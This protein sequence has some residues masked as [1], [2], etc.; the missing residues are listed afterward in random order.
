MELFTI[1]VFSYNNLDSLETTIRSIY[2]QTYP[3]IEVI[4]SDDCSAVSDISVRT[5]INNII[6]PYKNKFRRTYINVN[7][8]NVG[9]VK[10]INMVL[11]QI[12]GKYICLLGSGDQ[13]YKEDVL[14]KVVNF[15]KNTDY[16]LCYSK[17]LMPLTLNK[18][19][20]YPQHRV[21][22]A[23][24]RGNKD[25]LKLC[26]REVNHITTIGAFFTRKIFEKYEKFDENYVLLEDAPF[27]LTLLLDGVKIGF[28]DEIT[29]IHEKGGVSNSKM[30]NKLLEKDSVKTLLEIKYPQR[31]KFDKFTQRILKFKY[32]V[33]TGKK[34]LDRVYACV[35]YPDAALYLMIFLLKDWIKRKRFL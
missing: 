4:V 7:Q 17:Q 24:S 32:K 23:I 30:K 1:C 31:D 9:T 8:K 28:L 19:I 29:C 34:L 11:P 13:L 10:N 12:K 2:K 26:C 6:G 14:E 25:L 18:Q 15:F 3:D 33:R 27:F 22:K 16:L 5:K 21:I 35:W 20:I